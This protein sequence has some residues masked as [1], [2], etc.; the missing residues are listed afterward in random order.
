MAKNKNYSSKTFIRV[1][2]RVISHNKSTFFLYIQV[3]IVIVICILNCKYNI[4]GIVHTNLG[5]TVSMAE[6]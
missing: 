3:V 5:T 2:V 6:R 4:H 1:S